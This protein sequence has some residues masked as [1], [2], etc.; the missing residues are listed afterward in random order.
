MLK[1]NP[2]AVM[3]TAPNPGYVF[4]IGDIPQAPR[5]GTYQGKRTDWHD[6]VDAIKSGATRSELYTRFPDK[7]CRC[8]N[9]VNQMIS[10]YAPRR[11][12][13][14]KV[15]N[16]WLFGFSGT[17]KTE[18]ARKLMV[19]RF[20]CG[21]DEF[22]EPKIFMKTRGKWWGLYDY[23]EYCIQDDWRPGDVSFSQMLRIMQGVPLTIQDKGS[24]K[25]LNV[26]VMIITCPFNWD[27]IEVQT[28]AGDENMWQLG[29]RIDEVWHFRQ[30]TAA[31]IK[32]DIFPDPVRVPHDKR[33]PMVR[34][35]QAQAEGFVLPRTGPRANATAALAPLVRSNAIRPISPA[36]S[37]TTTTTTKRR[38]LF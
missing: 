20:K 34:P 21:L 12:W 23:Q 28:W 17:G 35:P 14:E 16:I 9:G 8:P 31:E 10:H 5:Q 25:H 32:G 11:K 36:C 29:R 22:G 19:D 6:L 24:H 18:Y 30:R 33:N 7:M 4:E 27:S 1:A 15:F 38:R 2:Q 13:G 3:P 37:S 26:K